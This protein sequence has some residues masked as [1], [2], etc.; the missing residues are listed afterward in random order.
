MGCCLALTSTQSVISLAAVS[1]KKS[2]WYEI[3]LRSLVGCQIRALQCLKD[4][5][6]YSNLALAVVESLYKIGKLRN[7]KQ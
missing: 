4:R 7:K 3:H 2:D 1:R 6:S 5:L